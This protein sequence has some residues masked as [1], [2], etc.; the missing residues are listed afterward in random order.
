LFSAGVVTPMLFPLGRVQRASCQNGAD[1][2]SDGETRCFAERTS[3]AIGTTS[4]Q[5]QERRPP[6][7]PEPA[8]RILAAFGI[9]G[10]RRA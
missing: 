10:L 1:S 4:L 3:R 6:G 9:G 5:A 2:E 8:V 7:L